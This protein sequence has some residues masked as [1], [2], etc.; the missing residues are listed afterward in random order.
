MSKK[1]FLLCSALLLSSWASQA[2][3][4][5]TTW[6]IDSS[7][8]W[9]RISI[10]DQPVPVPGVGTLPLGLR[11]Q[12]SVDG[13][14]P[15]VPAVAWADNNKRL[16]GIAGTWSTN[17]VEGSS[18]QFNNGSHTASAVNSGQWAPDAGSF[19]TVPNPDVF[20]VRFPGS[21]AN[22][23]AD[24]FLLSGVPGAAVNRL[25]KLSI[26]NATMSAGGTATLSP[27]G[28]NWTGSGSLAD[29]G[30][31][32]GAQLNLDWN[33]PGAALGIEDS[34]SSL[35]AVM[36]TLNLGTNGSLAVNNL[37]GLNREM[38]L[39]YTVPF[40][41]VIVAS[42]LVAVNGTLEVNVRSTA[43]VP[44]PASVSL[45]GIALGLCAFRRRRTV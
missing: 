19:T 25:I 30:H 44:E 18:L 17:Y 40:S 42:P 10:P 34:Q 33:L 14:P 5:L 4:A 32:A 24:V 7:A 27:S 29:H 31:A 43:V 36:N 3:A 35:G 28:P 45:V 2:R 26:A 12:A 22:Y 13:Q 39:T 20:T 23:A 8:S 37:G 41:M 16:T 1:V 9:A 21:A 11:G 38:I 6:T 15:A